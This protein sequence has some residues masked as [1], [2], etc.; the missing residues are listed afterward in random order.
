MKPELS[1]G[2]IPDTPP[3]VLSWRARTGADYLDE[4]WDGFYHVAP[5]KDD[6]QQAIEAALECWLMKAWAPRDQG[7]VFR[8]IRVARPTQFEV[9]Y[10]VPSLCLVCDCPSE[11]L[12]DGYLTV[13]PNVVIEVVHPRSFAHEKLDFYAQIGVQEVWLIDEDSRKV[14]LFGCEGRRFIPPLCALESEIVSPVTGIRIGNRKRELTFGVE[15][16][17]EQVVVF[18]SNEINF[19]YSPNLPR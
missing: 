13:T 7:R 1:K 5:E 15:F 11:V 12:H 14:D 4:V 18:S 16:S 9:D 3:E 17:T 19:S 10:R 2:I 8:E 6:L